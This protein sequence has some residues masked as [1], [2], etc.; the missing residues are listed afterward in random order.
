MEPE[1][2]KVGQERQWR[3]S[4]MCRELWNSEMPAILWPGQWLTGITHGSSI[5]LTSN[6]VPGRAIHARRP[7]RMALML[8]SI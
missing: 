8:A 2:S 7:S 3:R 1:G 4:S 5:L 6:L